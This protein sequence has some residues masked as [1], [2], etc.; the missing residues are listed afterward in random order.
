VKEIAAAE[1]EI[2]RREA[3]VGEADARL[4]ECR[5]ALHEPSTRCV[6]AAGLA[7]YTMHH[8]R[9]AAI[10]QLR[11]GTG[12][13]EIA[14]LFGRHENV[15]ETQDYCIRTRRSSPW[16]GEVSSCASPGQRARVARLDITP[17][18]VHWLGHTS[19]SESGLCS[20]SLLD[21]QCSATV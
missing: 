13:V 18:P 8:L 6:V 10:D 4:S 16:S 12:D 9:H 14:R 21:W 7:G 1:R 15:A 2:E 20:P 17:V 3:L 19:P 5:A 11:R